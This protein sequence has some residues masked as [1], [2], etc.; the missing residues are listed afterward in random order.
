MARTRRHPPLHVYQND[1]LVGHLHK[2]PG[3]AVAFHYDRQ[4]LDRPGTFPVS[5]SLP[6]REDAWRGECVVAVFENLVP[7]SIEL[8]RRQAEKVGSAGV[9]AY[10]LL[11]EIGRDC[12]GA[13]QFIV[14]DAEKPDSMAAPAD[15]EAIERL[16]ASLAQALFGLGERRF[17][18]FSCRRV[19]KDRPVNRLLID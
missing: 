10:S 11:T 14:G 5:L 9:D 7:D 8:R 17:P 1:Q 18:D 12:I 16:L 15:E 6:L 3:G 19:G 13:P 4:W 2:D